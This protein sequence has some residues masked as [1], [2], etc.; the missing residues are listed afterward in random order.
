VAF[1]EKAFVQSFFNKRLGKDKL[2]RH[3]RWCGTMFHL[4]WNKT[5]H[6]LEQH[7]TSAV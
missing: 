1:V 2:Y 5:T 6:Q 7:Y 3:S 4:W